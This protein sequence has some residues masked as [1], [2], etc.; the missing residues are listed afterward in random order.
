[1]DNTNKKK[2]YIKNSIYLNLQK[3]EISELMSKSKN[4][5]KYK[6]KLINKD[7]IN[8]YLNPQLN[9]KIMKILNNQ[10]KKASEFNDKDIN[11]IIDNIF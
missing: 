3:K 10:N 11:N 2:Q 1:M 4:K 5:D 6:L 7:I 8:G 9:E